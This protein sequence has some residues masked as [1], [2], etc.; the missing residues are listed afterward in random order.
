MISFDSF[1]W[2][3]RFTNGPKAKKYNK[4][5]DKLSAGEIVTSAVVHYEVYKKVKKLIGEQAAL[6][7]VAI[8]N[9]T[10]NV[11]V[12]PTLALE[13]ADYSLERSLH[14]S[15]ALIYATARKFDA[16]LYTSDQHLRELPHVTFV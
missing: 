12:D 16:K 8:L 1:G 7:N 2:I 13:A 14:F 5:F 3:E 6:E 10:M 11:P 9:Q 4:V 15:D